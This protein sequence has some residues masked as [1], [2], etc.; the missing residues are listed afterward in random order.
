M[1]RLSTA[2]L[3]L[4]ATL[5][6]GVAAQRFFYTPPGNGTVEAPS[7]FAGP[8]GGT[9]SQ[10]FQQICG[11]SGDPTAIGQINQ[12][13]FRRDNDTVVASGDYVAFSPDFTLTV[14]TS[15]RTTLTMSRTFAANIGNDATQV[16]TGV[17]NFPAQPKMPPGPTPFAY[18]VPF[19]APFPYASPNGDILLDFAVTSA[20]N[21]NTLFFCDAGASGAGSSA[22]TLGAGCPAGSNL[23]SVSSNWGPGSTGRILQYNAAGNVPSVLSFGSNANSWN[24][25]PLPIDL[26]VIGAP[27]CMVYH[28]NLANLVGNTS[29]TAGQY[30][31]RWDVWLELPNNPFLA[32]LQLRTQFFNLFDT[33][34]MNPA[35]LSVSAGHE[36]TFATPTPGVPPQSEAHGGA[37]ATT[38]ALLQQGYGI[39]AEFRFL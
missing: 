6:N 4:A 17:L 24:G 18:S 26:A 29:G 38:A 32:G 7:R 39:V 1:I 22:R 10:R 19:S 15:P 23:V 35:N 31:G 27:G 36:I 34:V 21:S 33:G 28:D 13:A 3:L 8:F 12:V 9:A 2:S 37:T 30:N 16:H 11:L 5:A 14:S 25:I 20:N